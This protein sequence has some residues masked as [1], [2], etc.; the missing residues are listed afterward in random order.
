MRRRFRYNPE[1]KRMDEIAFDA[2]TGQTAPM[3]MTDLPG[4]VSPTTGLWIEGRKARREDLARSGCRPFEGLQSEKR[5]ADR[6][7]QY[8]EQKTERHI[9]ERAREVFHQLP[10]RK[11]RVLEGR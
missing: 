8:A 6:R 2:P 10:P 3:L 1:T 4:Y 5:E 9:E 11:R 7:M